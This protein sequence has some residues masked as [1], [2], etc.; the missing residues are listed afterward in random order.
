[1]ERLFFTC[2]TTRRHV[3]VGVTTEIG[4]LLRIKSERLRARCRE[5]GEIHEWTVREATLPQA[6]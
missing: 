1:M 5:C 3:D 4:T 6:A 2:P